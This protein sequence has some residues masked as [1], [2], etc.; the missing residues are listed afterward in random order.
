MEFLVRI[1]FQLAHFPGLKIFGDNTG[2][3]E[4]WWMGRSRNP[5][6][7]RIFRRVHKLLE[8]ND[9][10]LITRYVNTSNNPADGPSRGNFPPEHLLL[11]PIAIPHELK[12]FIANFDSPSQPGLLAISGSLPP[13]PKPLVFYLKRQQRM[14]MNIVADEFPNSLTQVSAFN[15]SPE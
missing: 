8:E 14:Q 7:N 2:V 1:V 6:T 11:P 3:V 9:V 5:E 10:V 12:Q 15:R 4:G 13:M